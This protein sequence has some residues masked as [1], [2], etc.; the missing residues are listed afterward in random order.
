MAKKTTQEVADKTFEAHANDDTG[1]SLEPK[2][3]GEDMDKSEKAKKVTGKGADIAGKVADIA[4]KLRGSSEEEEA[5][6]LEPI[7]RSE[8]AT[9]LQKAYNL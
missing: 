1:L 2:K 6:V 3:K 9:I 7:D 5:A 4:G 8:E